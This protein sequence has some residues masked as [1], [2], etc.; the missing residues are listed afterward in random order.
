MSKYDRVKSLRTQIDEG[1]D[2]ISDLRNSLSKKERKVSNL[3]AE[4]QE[5]EST[6]S[7]TT[8]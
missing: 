3:Q 8:M 1:L 7:V 6:P 4:L 5:L 2:E